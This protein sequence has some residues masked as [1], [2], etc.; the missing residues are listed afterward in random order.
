MGLNPVEFSG[1]SKNIAGSYNEKTISHD[2]DS[3]ERNQS[4]LL[5]NAEEAS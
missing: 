4:V 2:T 5:P 3:E 1:H